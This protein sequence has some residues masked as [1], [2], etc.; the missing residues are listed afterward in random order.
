M[1]AKV[2]IEKFYLIL[3]P[4]PVYVIG[5][6]KM[7]EKVNFMAA[8][9]VMPMGE[10]PPLVC[11]AIGKNSLTNELINK[12]KQFSVNVLPVEKLDEIYIVG[13]VSGRDVDKTEIIKPIEGEELD[14]PVAKDAIAFLECT[15]WD[16]VESNDVTLF[17]GQVLNVKVNEKYFNLKTGWI[18]KDNPIPLH[19][20]GRGFFKIGQF[21]MV[22]KLK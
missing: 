4:R 7:K 10:D 6:G 11:I 2:N 18:T 14:V 9:W 12:Y 17:I 3:H 16:K 19:N 1:L 21:I 20:W 8:S 15:L 22:K 13:T 5:S